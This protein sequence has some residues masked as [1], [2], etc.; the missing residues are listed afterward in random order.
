[1]FNS[2]SIQQLD[3][4]GFI[5]QNFDD[6]PHN[7]IEEEDKIDK[8]KAKPPDYSEQLENKH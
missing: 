5:T 7:I 3:N 4:D 2:Q 6:S 1:M 8:E